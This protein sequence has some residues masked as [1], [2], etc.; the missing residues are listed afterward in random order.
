MSKLAKQKSPD[1]FN[2]NK[3]ICENCS[4]KTIKIQKSD[5]N[6]NKKDNFDKKLEHVLDKIKSLENEISVKDRKNEYANRK[7]EQKILTTADDYN[8]RTLDLL[9]KQDSFRSSV[10]GSYKRDGQ[11]SA[12]RLYRILVKEHP[13]YNDLVNGLNNSLECSRNK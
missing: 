7:L 13:E 10:S 6:K 11:D 4:S 2:S 1:S 8:N 5:D 12:T 3:N 9:A